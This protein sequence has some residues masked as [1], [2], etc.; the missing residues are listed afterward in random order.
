MRWQDVEAVV[1]LEQRSYPQTAWSSATWWAELAGRP[2]RAY[3]VH[4]DVGFDRGI[5]GYAG[6]DIGGGDAD[7]MTI[8]V[9]EEHRGTGVGARLLQGVH[10]QAI[11]AGARHMLL[12]VRADNASARR[13]YARNGYGAIG[14]REGYYPPDGV[15]AIVMRADL[16]RSTSRTEGRAE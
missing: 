7:L 4:L 9:D 6:I 16:D 12:E 11:A 2:R 1:A 15:D 3:L 14:R 8:T 5:A 10:E 13:L